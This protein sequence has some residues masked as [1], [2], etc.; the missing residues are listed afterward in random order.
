MA[1][2]G[3][4]RRMKLNDVHRRSTMRNDDSFPRAGKC[5]KLLPMLHLPKIH[6]PLTPL[7]APATTPFT[8]TAKLTR[9]QKR[10][11][12]MTSYSL[13]QRKALVA[14]DS[15]PGPRVLEGSIHLSQSVLPPVSASGASAASYP[16]IK[17]NLCTD[18]TRVALHVKHS[19]EIFRLCAPSPGSAAVPSRRPVETAP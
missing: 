1:N 12:Y 13:F 17:E 6:P 18:Y 19:P 8:S 7:A 2:D 3:R 14:N 11:R 9:R 10:V 15:Y 4:R 5:R 16:Q